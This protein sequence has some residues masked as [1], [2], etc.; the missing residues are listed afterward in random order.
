M[1]ADLLANYE[2][3]QRDRINVAFEWIKFMLGPL[4]FKK[5]RLWGVPILASGLGMADPY[6]KLADAKCRGSCLAAIALP[7][8]A[9]TS[10]QKS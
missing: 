7:R 4:S 5:V 1:K 3:P 6:Q 10:I 8:T 9:E 2:K